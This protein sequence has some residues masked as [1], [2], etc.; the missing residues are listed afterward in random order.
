MTKQST[1]R[2]HA[3]TNFDVITM[4]EAQHRP[5]TQSSIS[6]AAANNLFDEIRLSSP[7][8]TA[9]DLA[10]LGVN[11][12]HLPRL[13]NVAM[14]RS[15]HQVTDLSVALLRHAVQRADDEQ[16]MRTLVHWAR[17]RNNSSRRRAIATGFRRANADVMLIQCIGELPTNDARSFMKDYFE[18]GGQTIS[19]AQ[20]LQIVGSELR[21][22]ARPTPGTDGILDDAWNSVR[23]RVE[24]T[25]R[26]I[27]RAAGELVETVVD[28]VEEAGESI[29]NAVA[30]GAAWAVDRVAD[31]IAS[32]IEGGKSVAQILSKVSAQAMKVVK[33]ALRALQQ[34]HHTVSD[35]IDA[36]A[37]LLPNEL[38]KVVRALVQLGTSSVNIIVSF[39]NRTLD[40]I[41]TALEALATEG[42]RLMTVIRDIC[43]HVA[44]EIR[45][46]F[47]EGLIA[48]GKYTAKDS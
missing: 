44:E 5:V 31:V 6:A 36:A 8:V 46:G 9:N 16:A 40:G 10:R 26:R 30:D 29:V 13:M 47:I 12:D 1:Q 19:I 3:S 28:A 15:P 18:S 22:S 24:R 2:H 33:K 37:E 43:R 21:G 48:L 25:A 27:G 38:K 14:K 35:V 45:K 41:R 4:L 17:G 23:R 34:L 20:W 42:I 39:S 7:R 32:L 11:N